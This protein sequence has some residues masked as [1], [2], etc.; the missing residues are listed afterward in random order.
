MG[1][2]IHELGRAFQRISGFLFLAVLVG[3]PFA[4]ILPRQPGLV[5]VLALIG[6]ALV[7][8]MRHRPRA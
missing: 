8:A 2:W 5:L 6:A 1:L 4:V 3:V 7:R